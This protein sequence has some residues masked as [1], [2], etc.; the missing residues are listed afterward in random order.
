MN[1]KLVFIAIGGNLLINILMECW[2][3]GVLE[4]QHPTPIF[5]NFKQRSLGFFDA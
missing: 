2:R 5:C 4:K 3:N 1:A